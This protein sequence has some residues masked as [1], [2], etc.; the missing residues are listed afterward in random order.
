MQE[1]IIVKSMLVLHCASLYLSF[2]N[3]VYVISKTEMCKTH[4]QRPVKGRIKIQFYVQI[5]HF[6]ELLF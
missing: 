1:K 3:S 5:T 6:I 4:L 2:P